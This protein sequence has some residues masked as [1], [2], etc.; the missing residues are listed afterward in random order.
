[1]NT[2]SR[3]IFAD[4]WKLALL[5]LLLA[6]LLRLWGAFDLNE[7]IE[8]ES[9]HVSYAKDLGAYGTT[10][11]W[12][13]HHPQLSGLLI[14][15]T[16]RIFGDNPAG[17]RI[18]NIF[19]GTASVLLI[20]LIGRLLYPGSAVPIIAMSLFA[21]DPNNIYVSRTTFVEIPVTFFFLLYLYFLLEYTENR[22]STL[23]PAGIAM[24]LTMGTKAYFVFAIPIALVYAVYRLYQRNELNHEAIVDFVVALLFLPFAIYFMTYY[25]WFGRG[26]TL[27]D[28]INMKIDSIWALQQLNM[29]NFINREYLS[30]GGQPWEW[31]IKPMFWG[32][33][34]LKNAAE[35]ILLIQS[36]NPPFRLLVLPSLLVIIIYSF[37]K[38]F[39][40]ELLP[41]LLFVS[42]YVLILIAKRPIFSYSVTVLLPF[43][44]LILAHAVS[45]LLTRA[46]SKEPL[47]ILFLSM[48]LIWCAY[49]FPLVS[50]RTVAVAPFR[51]ILNILRYL[52]NF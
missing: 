13:W 38:H 32:H 51:P 4:N 29:Q 26:Y 1:M 23:F 36:N 25:K 19:S 3:S 22:R 42:C 2:P 7:Y 46:N 24:G 21:L 44:Y 49:I 28:F 43:A 10:A 41:L 45:L 37:K 14:Y 48:I 18:G 52:D 35:G 15:N 11:D 9:L 39:T 12:S 40:R 5:I 50:A 47:L 34:R 16:I 31:F 33:Q 30:A 8:D 6:A 17:W 20:F 27:I